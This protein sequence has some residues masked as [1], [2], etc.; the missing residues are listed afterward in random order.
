[1]TKNLFDAEIFPGLNE[2]LISLKLSFGSTA[3]K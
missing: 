2:N 1:M 3:S